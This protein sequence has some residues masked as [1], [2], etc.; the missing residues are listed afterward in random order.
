MMDFFIVTELGT[1]NFPK[2]SPA[3]YIGG[4]DHYFN[5][6][7]L[8]PQGYEDAYLVM[9]ACPTSHAIIGHEAFVMRGSG[10]RLGN[11]LRSVAGHR[12]AIIETENGSAWTQNVTT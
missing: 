8:G 12:G 1:G 5:E 6:G 3:F 11:V 2:D 7:S 4:R 10:P 9:K